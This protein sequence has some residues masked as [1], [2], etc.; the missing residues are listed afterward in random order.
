MATAPSRRRGVLTTLTTLCVA[1]VLTAT[2]ASAA[3]TPAIPDRQV[4]HPLHALTGTNA[5]IV[6]DTGRTV[7]LRGVNVNGLG[8]YYQEWPDLPANNQLTEAD[9]AEIAASGLN[10]VRLVISWSALEPTRGVIDNTY[11]D[12][13]AQ[14]VS[15][16]RAHDV[17]VLIDMHQDAWGTAVNTPDGAWCP[18]VL[19]ERAV[20][21]DGAPA[22]ATALRGT[23]ATCRLLGKR[24]ISV[25][26]Q[27]SFQNFYLDVNGV[28]SELVKTWAAVAARFAADPTVVG[29]DL[30]NE[31]NPGLLVGFND[32]LLLGKYY[33]RAIDA[34]R[35]AEGRTPGGFSHI[36]FFEPSVITGP[37]A[38]PGPVPGF[39]GDRNSVYAPHLY[40][41]SISPLPGSIADGFEAAAK[42]AGNYGTSVFNGEWGFWDSDPRV[43]GEK[44]RRYAAQEDKHLVSS[45]YWQWDQACGDPHNVGTRGHRPTCAPTDSG[46]TN[47][48]TAL[49]LSRAYPRAAA[50]RL[51]E[52]R[53]EID[54]GALTVT[55][56]ADR[57]GVRTE[58]WV[59]E[60]CANPVIG[61]QNVG[62]PQRQAIAGGWR[63]TL[64]VPATGDYR[65]EITCG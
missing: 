16:A 15:W 55:G 2:P 5:R 54:T 42:A 12:R 49:A 25:A 30:L 19:S 29:Y 61:G 13:I 14:A 60:R 51:T 22:W 6:D 24:E 27:A 4:D 17:Y 44:S 23:S 34:I 10:V 31:P 45:T 32:Y 41:E 3:P 58:M 18:P 8:E 36:A 21:W 48:D 56:L 39:S 38:F 47:P 11:L 1:A 65:A 26:V 62:D 64:T 50:G 46:I 43:N 7:L 20:G 28:Q 57:A 53:S 63:I 37:L 9:F 40:N 33:G 52:T 35:A 59:P